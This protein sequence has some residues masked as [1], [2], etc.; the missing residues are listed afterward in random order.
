ML[1]IV[2][3]VMTEHELQ[4][5]S[6]SLL[7]LVDK[8]MS[9]YLAEKFSAYIA[10]PDADVECVKKVQNVLGSTL[11]AI[12]YNK[13]LE[14]LDLLEVIKDVGNIDPQIYS[15]SSEIYKKLQKADEIFPKCLMSLPARNVTIFKQFD[16]QYTSLL[17]AFP[18]PEI[19]NMLQIYKANKTVFYKKG[20]PTQYFVSNMYMTYKAN[21]FGLKRGI[22]FA[23]Y[24][25]TKK[26]GQAMRVIL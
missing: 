6:E 7:A 15:T 11:K 20:E 3:G 23:S 14:A 9:K 5:I 19:P 4:H 12:D 24:Y 13:E 26:P 25:M 21:W 10:N 2:N 22:D 18:N 1:N 17:Q 16:S 8:L